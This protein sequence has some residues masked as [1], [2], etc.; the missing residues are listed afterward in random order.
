MHRLFGIIIAI[1]TLFPYAAQAQIKFTPAAKPIIKEEVFHY[2][3]T[4]NFPGERI[5]E[6]KGQELYVIPRAENLREFGYRFFYTSYHRTT[7]PSNNTETYELFAGRTFI[8][9][10]ILPEHP[11]ETYKIKERSILKLRDKESGAEYYYEYRSN[12]HNSFPFII[13]GYYEKEKSAC[14]GKQIVLK[15]GK[16]WRKGVSW[17]NEPLYDFR[18]GEEVAVDPNEPWTVEDLTVEEQYFTLSYVIRNA[19]GETLTIGI[20][21]V[22]AYKRSSSPCA[23]FLNDTLRYVKEKLPQFY[24]AIMKSE[25]MIGMTP[26]LVRYAWGDPQSITETSS[27]NMWSCRGNF[28]Y[29]KDGKL[30]SFR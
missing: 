27:G 7:D 23:L 29:F 15:P 5:K 11:K 21:D 14:L 24:D 25:V 30:V 16:N 3:S 9:E 19:K 12:F 10:E 6:L 4:Y 18:T 28:L 20:S 26:T 17:E 1:L 22:N 2:D 8:V 13:M